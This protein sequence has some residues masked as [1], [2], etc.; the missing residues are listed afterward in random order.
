MS[1]QINVSL[2]T[3]RAS[4]GGKAVPDGPVSGAWESRNVHMEYQSRTTPSTG[5]TATR[6]HVCVYNEH[7]PFEI[8]NARLQAFEAYDGFFPPPPPPTN[9]TDDPTWNVW[10]NPCTSWDGFDCPSAVDWWDA[11]GET[12]SNFEAVLDLMKSCPVA[13]GLTGED[14]SEYDVWGTCNAWSGFPYG[15]TEAAWVARWPGSNIREGNTAEEE[16]LRLIQA[17]PKATNVCG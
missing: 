3:A 16:V 8:R 6:G 15:D 12:R 13:C 1:I 14:D 7:H 10:N 4:I 11:P 17:C 9:C 2:D 5:Q